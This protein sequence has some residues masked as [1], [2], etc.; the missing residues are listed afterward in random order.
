MSVWRRFWNWVARRLRGGTAPCAVP[1]AGQG[2]EVPILA[3]GSETNTRRGVTD[4]DAA[5]RKGELSGEEV[6]VNWPYGGETDSGWVDFETDPWQQ[7]QF[8]RA[9]SRHVRSQGG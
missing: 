5:T 3:P 9:W 4:A 2:A 8:R 6:L 7:E 1:E